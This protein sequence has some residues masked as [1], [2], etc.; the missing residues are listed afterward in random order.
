MTRLADRV[1]FNLNHNF[2]FKQVLI[3]NIAPFEYMQDYQ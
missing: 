2:G 1:I 3:Y